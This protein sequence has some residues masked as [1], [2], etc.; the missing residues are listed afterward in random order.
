MPTQNYQNGARSLSLSPRAKP[1]P[2]ARR[3]SVRAERVRS[4]EN[5]PNPSKR[6]VQYIRE[7]TG[8]QTSN[9][10]SHALSGS[11]RT[12]TRVAVA[13]P[14][15]SRNLPRKKRFFLV[16][17][18]QGASP[19]HRE[20]SAPLELAGR[21]PPSP[22]ETAPRGWREPSVPRHQR[23]QERAGEKCR[24]SRMPPSISKGVITPR[25]VRSSGSLFQ[26]GEA[27]WNS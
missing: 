18:T 17:K 2:L 16:G 6:L 7:P 26:T 4:R 27:L 13:P 21:G 25:A 11:Y 5:S 3:Q 23:P 10:D 14:E 22:G 9:R 8:G 19:G 15:Q 24:L 20:L 12:A 1:R